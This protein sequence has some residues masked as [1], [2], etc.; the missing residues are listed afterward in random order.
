MDIH[1]IIVN[2]LSYEVESLS[3][4]SVSC[5]Q[6]ALSFVDL[7]HK[8]NKIANIGSGTGYQSITL[9]ETLKTEIYSIDHRPLYTKLL[10]KELVTQSLNK[11]IHAEYSPI[12][13]LPFETN[14]LDLVWAESTAKDAFFEDSLNNWYKYIAPNGYIG[15]C[16]YCW[17]SENKPKDVV[18]F[19]TKQK[20]DNNSI[21]KRLQQM[22]DKGFVPVAHFTMPEECW[23]NYFCPLDINRDFILKK[24]LYSKEVVDIMDT[25][26]EEITLFEKYG[27][28]YKYVFFIGKKHV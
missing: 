19:F 6:K 18:N 13:C 4:Y 28:T 14:G 25:I 3:P 12:D 20:I 27:N 10:Q 7:P 16:A 5:T 23:W 17:E 8:K 15:I 2:D 9:L 21:L 26:D 1:Q 11:C 24:Y 22:N